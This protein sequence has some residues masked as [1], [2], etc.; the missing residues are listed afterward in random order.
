MYFGKNVEQPSKSVC[1]LCV[2]LIRFSRNM[3]VKTG[4]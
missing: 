2:V 3:N 1:C 4:F